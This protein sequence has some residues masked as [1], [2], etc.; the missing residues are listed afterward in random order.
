MVCYFNIGLLRQVTSAGGIL[1]HM[2]ILNE[3]GEF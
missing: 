3:T 1:L 2:E